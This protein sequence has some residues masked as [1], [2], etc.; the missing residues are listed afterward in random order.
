[1]EA[2][3][4]L[5]ANT[6]EVTRG[7]WSFI[8][9]DDDQ[10]RAWDF[11]GKYAQGEWEPEVLDVIADILKPGDTYVDVGAWVGPTALWAAQYCDHVL[12]LEPDPTAAA[13]LL[14]NIGM[15]ASNISLWPVALTDQIGTTILRAQGTWGDSTSTIVDPTLLPSHDLGQH[16]REVEVR[17]TDVETL[18]DRVTGEYVGDGCQLVKVD[19]E[20]G[21]HLIVDRLGDF[22]C[23]VILSLHLPWVPDVDDLVQRV[24]A[25][26][27]V[28]YLDEN[29]EFPVVLITP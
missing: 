19:I 6:L 7:P 24:H 11:W 15:N 14:A 13:V 22:R 9:C 29:T 21:E 18:I 3:T 17:A 10:T 27:H 16:L 4:G 28:A 26:G 2:V 20:G 25:L 5:C 23:P 1:M 8:V 12:A